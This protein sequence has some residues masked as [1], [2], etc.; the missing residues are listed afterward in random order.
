MRAPKSAA[1]FPSEDMQI[2][3]MVLEATVTS[4]GG[5]FGSTAELLTPETAA[6]SKTELAVKFCT[7]RSDP[8]KSTTAIRRSGPA[9]ASINF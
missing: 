6:R 9:L 5:A 4:G 3:G 1:A 8:P 2:V 7:M